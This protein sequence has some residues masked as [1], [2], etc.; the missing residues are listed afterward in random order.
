[1]RRFA[2]L[3]DHTEL[4][5]F[6]HVKPL[7]DREGCCKFLFLNMCRL[8]LSWVIRSAEVPPT[9]ITFQARTFSEA[10][11]RIFPHGFVVVYVKGH[12]LHPLG[13]KLCGLYD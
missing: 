4:H 6:I 3:L 13:R 9:T 8:F 1:M 10:V 11:G 5:S 12:T 2:D 7:S